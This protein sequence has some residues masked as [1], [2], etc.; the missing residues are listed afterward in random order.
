MFAAYD[1]DVFADRVGSSGTLHPGVRQDG[2]YSGAIASLAYSR[3]G[4][5]VSGGLSSAVG[6]NKYKD[7]NPLATSPTGGKCGAQVARRTGVSV[8]GAAVY[9][10]QFRLGVFNDPLSLTG[11][12]DPF[13]SVLPDLA[14]TVWRLCVEQPPVR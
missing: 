13:T 4:D 7:R 3:R 8:T 2:I 5:R 12:Q 11:S 14:S 9:S 1:D 6:V 10:P